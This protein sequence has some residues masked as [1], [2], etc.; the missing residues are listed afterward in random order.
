MPQI[1]AKAFQPKTGGAGSGFTIALS[2]L[3]S[4]QYIRVGI[5]ATGQKEHFGG[6]LDPEKDAIKLVLDT[7]HGKTHMM[8][9]EL[10]DADEADALPLAGGIKGSVS[11]KVQPWRQVAAG[12]RP[13]SAL[14]LVNSEK[15]TAVVVKLP[16]WARPEAVKIGQGKRLMEC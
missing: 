11:V 8:R 1:T 7:D 2:E 4:G 12:K 5:T 6:P 16:E 10:A 14:P 13:A 3:K 15:Q 9:I